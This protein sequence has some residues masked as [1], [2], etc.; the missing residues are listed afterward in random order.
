MAVKGLQTIAYHYRVMHSYQ[1]TNCKVEKQT[2]AEN[3]ATGTGQSA[4]FFCPSEIVSYSINN[5]VYEKPLELSCAD[6]YENQKR[7]LHQP[8]A[9]IP[10]YVNP[11]NYAEVIFSREEASLF[12][13]CCSVLG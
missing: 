13:M 9:T 5:Q 2:L 6:S 4:R 1:V 11:R 3:V 12:F 8:G 10:C 7:Y